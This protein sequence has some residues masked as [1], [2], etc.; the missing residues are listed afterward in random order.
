MP[1]PTRRQRIHQ[2]LEVAGS[3]DRTSRTVDLALIALIGVN[4]LAVMLESIEPLY[5]AHR[6]LFDAVEAASL[7]IFGVEYLLRLWSAAERADAPENWASPW[8]ARL[9]WALSPLA[10]ADLAAILPSFLASFTGVD[11]RFLRTLRLLRVFKLTRYSSSLTMFVEV[12]RSQGRAYA[13]AMFVLGLILVVAASGIYVVEREAQP[14]EFASI[15]KAMWWALVTLTTVGYGDVTPI[16]AG[17]K[18]FASL[19]TLVGVGVV[20]LPTAILASGFLAEHQRRGAAQALADGYLDD[21]EVA[22]YHALAERLGMAPEVAEEIMGAA[23]SRMSPRDDI[24][25]HCGK[26]LSEN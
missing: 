24:C 6:T 4:V 10:L 14:E 5:R 17:G 9:R 1:S 22:Q 26:G 11:L 12:A 21:T 7:A 20:A 13:A 3:G 16:T 19:V 23:L 25:P 2:I 15:P 18:L 8:R